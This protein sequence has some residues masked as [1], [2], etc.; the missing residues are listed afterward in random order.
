MNR[1][2][3]GLLAIGLLGALVCWLVLG[4]MPAYFAAWLFWI[5]VPMGAL[6][7][8]MAMEASAATTSPLLPVLRAML[9]LLPL[10]TLLALPLLGG[11]SDLF[12]RPGL[13]GA[14]PAWWTAPGALALR[15]GV[16]LILL[17]GLALLFWI[18]PRAPRRSIAVAGLLLTLLFATL[19]AVDL[20]LA[21]QP[22]LGSSL[23]GLMLIAGQMA[24][25]GSLAAFVVAVG[26]APSARLPG[27]AGLLLG[28]LVTAWFFV[29]FVQFL[30]VWSANLPPE[31]AWY[32]DRLAGIGTAGIAFAAIA[33]LAAMALL[34]SMLGRIPLVM[35]TLAT[36]VVLAALV[37]TLLFVIPAYRG[38]L[39]LTV[40][41]ALALVGI[42]GLSIGA[43]L[44][45]LP[46]GDRHEAA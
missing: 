21:P 6:P 8:V 29:Q 25:A 22:A 30:V 34:P 28:L 24:L 3:L 33:A 46:K 45:L 38:Q 19:L 2:A 23:A 18:R 32:L 43:L 7:I 40:A 41:D 35:A 20:V 5:G 42:G 10:G 37:V 39:T 11:L 13:P 12:A 36:M 31:A 14:L 17:S 15:D 27:G 26:S 4:A 44:L 9:P 1:P 16:V